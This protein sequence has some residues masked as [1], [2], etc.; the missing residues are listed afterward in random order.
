MTLRIKTLIAGGLTLIALISVLYMVVAH[1]LLDGFAKI[2]KQQTIASV[3][4]AVH[5]LN[6]ASVPLQ[7]TA[8]AWS[9]WSE[10]YEFIQ[11]KDPKVYQRYVAKNLNDGILS[12]N[13]SDIV[14]Y[15]RNTGHVVY[16]TG[17]SQQ[18]GKKVPVPSDVLSHIRADSILLRHQSTTSSNRGLILLR[19]GPLLIVSRPIVNDIA[20]GPIRGSLIWGRYLDTA[21]IKEIS[22]TVQLPLVFQRLDTPS[23]PPNFQALGLTSSAS[24]TIVLQPQSAYKI[25]GYTTIKDIY[26]KPALILRVDMTRDTY[27]QGQLSLRYLLAALMVVSLVFGALTLWG[28]EH[29]VLARMS[30]LTDNVERIS[31]SG[32]I[33]QR[34]PVTGSD[35]LSQLSSSVNHLLAARESA[36]SEIYAEIDARKQIEQELRQSRDELEGRVVERTTELAAANEYL[37]LAKEKSDDVNEELR[38]EIAERQR[39]EADVQRSRQELQNLID[40]MTTL[41]AKIAPDGTFLIVNKIAIDA[42]GLSHEEY[43]KTNFLSGPWWAFDP[44]VQQRVGEK[45]QQALAG[46]PINYEE[47]IF[48]FGETKDDQFQSDSDAQWRE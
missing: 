25:A 7:E 3:K 22:Q 36:Q 15:V 28:L 37:Q 26:G 48:V 1:L 4:N 43:M 11:T 38:T 41:A 39:A 27:Q 12:S 21:K 20:K 18:T 19:Q 16:A 33:S 44:E 40:A 14:I 5:A 32:D 45:F 31:A 30:L 23:L 47:K 35:E 34:V 13:N 8:R 46:T 17:F 2:E 42:S 6:A 24:G 9:Q 10:S 29:W